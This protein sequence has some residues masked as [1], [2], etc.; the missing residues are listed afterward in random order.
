MEECGLKCGKLPRPVITSSRLLLFLLY[1]EHRGPLNELL[2]TYET[3]HVYCILL[4]LL[5]F[6]NYL[7]FHGSVL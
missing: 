3:R 1:L 2:L 4:D 7:I 5:F 6:S